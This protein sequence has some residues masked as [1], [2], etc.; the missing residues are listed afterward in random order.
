MVRVSAHMACLRISVRD[1]LVERH[2]SKIALWNRYWLSF[3]LFALTFLLHTARSL[4]HPSPPIRISSLCI[5]H[6]FLGNLRTCSVLHILKEHY[7]EDMWRY[8]SG[9]LWEKPYSRTAVMMG[10]ERGR[11]VVVPCRSPE[12]RWSDSRSGLWACWV[13]V[14]Q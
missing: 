3:S 6:K 9:T 7:P 5:S 10:E 8:D 14:I 11:T 13:I 2:T 4:F 1:M 12:H